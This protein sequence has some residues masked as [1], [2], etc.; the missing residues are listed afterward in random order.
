MPWCDS[1]PGSWGWGISLCL[2]PCLTHQSF[3]HTG[4]SVSPTCMFDYHQWGFCKS[5]QPP[6]FGAGIPQVRSVML[7]DEQELLAQ[8]KRAGNYSQ[9]EDKREEIVLWGN[10]WEEEF[11]ARSIFHRQYAPNRNVYSAVRFSPIH[12]Y[13]CWAKVTSHIQIDC[14]LLCFISAGRSSVPPVKTAGTRPK[15]CRT[16][17]LLGE[18]LQ[19][20]KIWISLCFA[21]KKAEGVLWLSHNSDGKERATALPNWGGAQAFTVVG[22]S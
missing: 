12:T 22:C 2:T 7:W 21:G 10:G 11:K 19:N 1:G 16:Y 3:P 9:Q 17:N 4:M 13:G 18:A 5:A 14:T 20:T 8:R 15:V 6:S